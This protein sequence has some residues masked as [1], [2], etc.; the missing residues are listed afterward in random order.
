MGRY[1]TMY[2]SM[3]IIAMTWAYIVL[4]MAV[5]AKSWYMG[6]LLF[7]FLALIPLGIAF[8]MTVQKHKARAERKAEA[9]QT[10]NHEEKT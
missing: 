3:L 9:A 7:V 2:Q 5:T 4:M 1:V 6:A 10:R 8:W